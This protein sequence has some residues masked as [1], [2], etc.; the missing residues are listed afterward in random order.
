MDRMQLGHLW[1][2]AASAPW[3]M[4]KQPPTGCSALSIT[5]WTQEVGRAPSLSEPTLLQQLLRFSILLHWRGEGAP[6]LSPK[7]AEYTR[8]PS[9]CFSC[10]RWSRPVTVLD[11]SSVCTERPGFSCTWETRGSK[12]GLTHSVKS[13]TTLTCCHPGKGH[14]RNSIN[15]RRACCHNLGLSQLFQS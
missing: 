12:W 11:F 7:T 13:C 2:G 14:V 5:A 3:N 1:H 10:G 4:S 9:A 15:T 8:V 6:L